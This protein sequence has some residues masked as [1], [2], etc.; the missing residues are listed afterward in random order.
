MQIQMEVWSAEVFR[1]VVRMWQY[2]V[3]TKAFTKHLT[4]KSTLREKKTPR[5]MT[6][7]S[8][9]SARKLCLAQQEK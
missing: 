8:W 1:S 4:Q 5:L 2:R 9:Q 3:G 7:A 6:S